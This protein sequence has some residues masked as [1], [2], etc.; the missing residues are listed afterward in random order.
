[1]RKKVLLGLGMIIL[2]FGAWVIFDY[3]H[4]F[5]PAIG[6]EEIK[7]QAEVILK[8]DASALLRNNNPNMRK[9]ISRLDVLEVEEI[10]GKTYL[11]FKLDYKWNGPAEAMDY[12]INNGGY[13]L[14]LRMVEKKLGGI[15]L[16][17]GMEFE[18]SYLGVGPVD[19]GQD[20]NGVFYGF[21][22]DPRVSRISLETKEGKNIQLKVKQRVIL[23]QLPDK[24]TEVYPHFYTST[25]S[26]IET[27]YSMKVAFLSKDEKSYQQYSNMPIEW[28]ALKAMDS[29]FLRT[30]D[31]D[32]IWVFP[33]QQQEA[34][35]GKVGEK[36]RDLAV[37]G[38]PIIFVGLRDTNKLLPVFKL[39]SEQIQEVSSDD[40][41][42]LYVGKEDGK[43]GIGAISVAD[44]DVF[45]FVQKSLVLRYQ[46]QNY[47]AA[48]NN[49][50]NTVSK[51]SHPATT[52]AEAPRTTVRPSGNGTATI[53]GVTK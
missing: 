22:K 6:Q 9:E 36:L 2:V 38:I 20:E 48:E 34:L 31:V 14:G 33:D 46:L 40:I 16:R 44:E 15:S 29:T 13:I 32:A 41:E 30:N 11:V 53:K 21:C 27:S 5:P 17:G 49:S 12:G 3:Y 28:W 51:T 7:Q 19:C 24:N 43:L 52:K 50:G 42:A 37:E 25:N 35:Q 47:M 26:E 1:M 8:K 18:S 10:K 45:P 23:A 4:Y 39:K